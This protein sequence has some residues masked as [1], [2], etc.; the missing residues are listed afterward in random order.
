MGGALAMSSQGGYPAGG[1]PAGGVGGV[2][3]YGTPPPSQVRWGVPCQVSQGGTCQVPARGYPAGGCVPCWGWW[4]TQYG[5]PLARSGQG[6]TLG[7]VTPGRVPPSQ[8]RRGGTQLGQQEGVV[9]TWR[10]VCLL[11]SRRRTFLLF[12]L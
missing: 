6:G 9:T 2:P 10:A 1:Y 7:R 11:R 3:R 4:G 8:V 5:T 12:R